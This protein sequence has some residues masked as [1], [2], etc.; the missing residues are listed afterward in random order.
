M[1]V[2]ELIEFLT[3][4]CDLSATVEAMGSNEKTVDVDFV[5][6]CTKDNIVRFYDSEPNWD[7]CVDEDIKVSVQERAGKFASTT[8]VVLP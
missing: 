5:E 3:T 6:Y 8:Y 4:K 1:T 7:D 2:R